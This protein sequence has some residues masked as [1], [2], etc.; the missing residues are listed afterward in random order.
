[1][2]VTALLTAI[3]T[4]SNVDNLLAS[5]LPGSRLLS[6]AFDRLEKVGNPIEAVGN[7]VEAVGNPVEAVG[8]PVE[9]VGNPVDAV[10][11]L[12]DAVCIPFEAVDTKGKTEV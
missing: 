1:M 5:V 6:G 8:N 9:A 7:P 4:M 3:T 12:V 10:G 11:N 2:I